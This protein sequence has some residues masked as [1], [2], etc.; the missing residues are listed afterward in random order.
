MSDGKAQKTEF[1]KFLDSQMEEL[2]AMSDEEV[3]DG[4][5]VAELRA[6]AFRMLAS[7]RAEA[8][9]RRLA[10]ARSLMAASKEDAAKPIQ[11]I[12]VTQAKA[13]IQQV[14]N[15]SRFTLA[16]RELGEMSDED[17]LRLYQQIRSLELQG[18]E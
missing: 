1:E 12:S 2:R 18:D 8:G 14:A 16:A 7:A 11:N 3:L 10:K 5:N 9:R 13:Y 17:V 4:I 15:D 6:Q